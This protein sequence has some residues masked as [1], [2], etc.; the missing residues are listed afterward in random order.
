MA[1]PDGLSPSAL[2]K[3]TDESKNGQHEV[4]LLQGYRPPYR[5]EEVLDFLR[6][7]AIPGVECI[8][9]EEYIRTVRHLNCEGKEVCG[10]VKVAHVPQKNALA[11]SVSEA[12]LPVL[13]QVLAR[14]R[15]QFDL[16]CEPQAVYEAL[17]S[18]NEIQPGLCALG[19]R[20]PGSYDAFEMAVRAILGQQITV[21]AAGTLAGRLAESFGVPLKS[22]V[23]GLTYLFPTPAELLALEKP[24]EGQLGPL[25]IIATRSRTIDALAQ[26]LTTG[27]INLASDAHP[28]EVVEKLQEIK[29]IGK[30][31]AHY[32]AMRALSWPDAF[33]ETDLGIK[34]AL[35]PRT[36]KEMLSL[37]EQWRPWRSYANINLW[38]SLAH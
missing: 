28:E 37:A 31:T 2:R 29:G 20:L 15:Q 21:K 35:A 6:F 25:G 7:R 1:N 19:T 33:L 10:W 27:T 11:V 26:G 24:L 12:L 4:T 13:P 3:Q 38:Y 32:L 22:G 30:W 14:I 8:G 5:W 36:S 17:A 9:E 16:D 18:M 23:A 34:K